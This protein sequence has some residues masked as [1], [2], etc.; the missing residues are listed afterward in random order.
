VISQEERKKRIQQRIKDLR[1]EVRADLDA[2]RK[3]MPPEQYENYHRH[4]VDNP[5]REVKELLA[6]L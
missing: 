5:I 2:A 1:D 4:T 6:N 3:E